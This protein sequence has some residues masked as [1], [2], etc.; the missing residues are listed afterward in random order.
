MRLPSLVSSADRIVYQPPAPDEYYLGQRRLTAE[1][2]DLYGQLID[3]MQGTRGQIK[4]GGDAGAELGAA[5]LAVALDAVC[6]GPAEAVAER[7]R[8]DPIRVRL[9]PAGVLLLA[10]LT[11]RLG[12]SFRICKGGLREGVILE[13]IGHNFG[14]HLYMRPLFRRL[15][16]GPVLATALLADRR[17]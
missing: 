17:A 13:M 5:E 9:L 11:R 15:E 8:L 1:L 7:V 2:R 12:R 6:A 3:G 4:V 10:E 14:D 16:L